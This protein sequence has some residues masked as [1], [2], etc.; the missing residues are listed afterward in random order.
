MIVIC[1]I[2]LIIIPVYKT[3]PP[4]HS[5]LYLIFSSKIKKVIENNYICSKKT[6]TRKLN[7]IQLVTSLIR[8]KIKIKINK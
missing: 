7:P 5:R 6:K 2:H 8:K 1:H 4:T 3:N